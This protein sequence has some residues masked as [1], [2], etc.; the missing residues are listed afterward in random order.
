MNNLSCGF[1]GLEFFFYKWKFQIFLSAYKAQ[2][3]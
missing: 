1:V 3:T 2:D